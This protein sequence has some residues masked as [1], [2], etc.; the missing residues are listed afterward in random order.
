MR[1]SS[2][3]PGRAGREFG[4]FAKE[5]PKEFEDAVFRLKTGDKPV[6]KPVRVPYLP[7]C[8]EEK[9]NEA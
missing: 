3:S 7:P 1:L 9:T 2:L 4:V 5:M 6:V 8:G